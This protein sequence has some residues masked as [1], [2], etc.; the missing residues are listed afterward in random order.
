[1]LKFLAKLFPSKSTKD[2]QRILPIVEEINA[3]FEQYQALSDEE[4]KNK[5]AE[6]R[7]RISETIKTEVE[8]L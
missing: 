2:I 4:L 6:F 3:H 7:A 8:E 5:T 1:M